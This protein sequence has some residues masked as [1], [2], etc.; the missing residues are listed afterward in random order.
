MQKK[1]VFWFQLGILAILTVLVV[2]ACQLAAGPTE[3]Y[4]EP[5]PIP[6][7]TQSVS[8]ATPLTPNGSYYDRALAG[9]FTGTVVTI[10]GLMSG[11]DAA[12]FFSTLID[13]EKNT[14]IDIQYDGSMDIESTIA[15][16]IEGRDAVD[17]VDIPQPGMLEDFARA[18]VVV[19]VLTYMDIG[20]LKEHYN[21]SWLQMATVKGPDGPIMAGVWHH[22]NAKSLVWYPKD[23]FEAAGYQTPITWE[24]LLEL[25]DAIVA[26]GHTP[27]CIGIENGQ[28]TGWPATDWLEDIIL[29]TTSLENYDRWVKGE[30]TFSSDEVKNAA[31][32][33]SDILLNEDYVLGGR[34]GLV[35]TFSLASPMPMFDEPPGCW[36]HR[37]G[38]FITSFFPKGVQAGRDYDFFYLPQIDDNFGKPFL[39]GGDLMAQF[40]DRPEVRA[41]IEY[42]TRGESM[43]AW[44]AT[45]GALSP[46]LDTN[47]DWYG[48]EVE[49]G[50]AAL[51]NQATSFRFD[52]SDLMPSEVG[53]GS[54]LESITEYLSGAID[55][56]TALAQIDASW[57][58]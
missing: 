40:N 24:E 46:H 53:A 15:R 32:I 48:N 1:K 16:Q 33:M 47:L 52:G 12:K 9:E 4:F 17:I 36:L 44:L 22:F 14:G 39:V 27:W 50:V 35:S 30:L 26:D 7:A 43:K 49:R 56:D 6:A 10:A 3:P 8:G 41:L 42:F 55:L 13:F 11:E 18:G 28:W 38:N 5:T 51:A 54:F 34:A 21:P 29:R 19:D 37:Q 2:S 20:Y 23:A 25:S 45:G 57:P 31:E 58:E